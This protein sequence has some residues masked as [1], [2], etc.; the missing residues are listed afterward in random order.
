MKLRQTLDTLSAQAKENG[1]KVSCGEMRFEDA[2]RANSDNVFAVET[3]HPEMFPSP[4]SL[5]R[6]LDEITERAC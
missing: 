3:E 6:L 5:I 4:D 1:R 2:V